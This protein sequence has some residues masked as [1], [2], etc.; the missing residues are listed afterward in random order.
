MNKNSH[1]D[2]IR[3]AYHGLDKIQ[4][5]ARVEKPV[6]IKQLLEV[7]HIT[8]MNG[9]R[10][11]DYVHPD[12]LGYEKGDHEGLK[13]LIK[14]NRKVRQLLNKLFQQVD[15][16]RSDLQLT[17]TIQILNDQLLVSL[18]L[19]GYD[20]ALRAR[21]HRLRKKAS[22]RDLDNEALIDVWDK[23]FKPEWTIL[24]PD[25]IAEM[26]LKLSDSI[27]QRF[28]LSYKKALQAKGQEDIPDA[29]LERIG[30]HL[31]ELVTR[32]NR[33]YKEPSSQKVRE[34]CFKIAT[35][36]YTYLWWVVVSDINEHGEDLEEDPEF[37]PERPYL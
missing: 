36:L 10:D 29:E 18:W 5:Q 23:T 8:Y 34:I 17:K 19:M 16:D 30:A 21:L 24:G 9:K 6:G 32:F 12:S 37:D 7:Y 28:Y 13:M 31:S 35:E 27:N 25:R 4:K 1:F 26:G 2:L 3:L 22:N 20:M 14:S 33:L 11:I 15:Q